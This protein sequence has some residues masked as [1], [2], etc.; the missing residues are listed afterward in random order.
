MTRLEK[1]AYLSQIIGAAAVVVSLIYVG[2]QISDNT[3]EV[4]ANSGRELIVFGQEIDSWLMT[5]PDLADILAAGSSDYEA[6]SP[7]HRLRFD[8]YVMTS[9][10]LY[11]G[12]FYYHQ[13]GLLNEEDWTTWDAYFR[14]RMQMGF[15]WPD[16]KADDTWRRIYRA[17]G[18]GYGEAF[19]RHVNS[20]LTN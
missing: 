18:E 1:A 11:E 4:R 2:R 7:S 15:G 6:L 20:V 16:K 5:N 3:T 14:G 19:R 13:D 8:Q 10:N 12:A 17:G 9:L